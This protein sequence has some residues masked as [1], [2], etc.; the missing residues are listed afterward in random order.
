[1]WWSPTSDKLA[2]VK[3][4]DT[5]V[6]VFT[7]ASYDGTPYDHLNRLRYP[8]PDTANPQAHLFVYHVSGE[9]HVRLQLPDSLLQ[10]FGQDYYVWSVSWLTDDSLIVVYVNRKQNRAIT[11]INDATTGYV[12]LTKLINVK[13]K[14]KCL[15]ILKADG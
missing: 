11:V 1:M 12:L 6:R 8:K 4:N 13:L 5:L 7:Y 2:Y 10:L 15:F 9:R 14:K 3:F